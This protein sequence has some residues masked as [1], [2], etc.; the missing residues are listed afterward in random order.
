LAFEHISN[1][2]TPYVDAVRRA[3]GLETETAILLMDSALPRTSRVIFQKSGEKNIIAITFP[4]H[5]ANLF[6]V[7][8]FVFFA[9][10]SK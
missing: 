4:T 9:V 6:Q 1:V 2:F 7:L 5:T 10:L 8:D 3:P